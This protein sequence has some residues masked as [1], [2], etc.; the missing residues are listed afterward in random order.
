MREVEL[1]LITAEVQTAAAV[2]SP[3]PSRG[4]TAVTRRVPRRSVFT[5]TDMFIDP[6][7]ICLDAFPNAYGVTITTSTFERIA[8]ARVASITLQLALLPCYA[9]DHDI[10][11]LLGQQCLQA[12]QAGRAA[13]ADEATEAIQLFHTAPALDH[14]N[15]STSSVAGRP[16]AAALALLR[17]TIERVPPLVF[18]ITPILVH[19]AE[20]LVLP[21]PEP[22][23][24]LCTT[25]GL[26]LG[27]T[28]GRSQDE[29]IASLR[30]AAKDPSTANDRA[31]RWQKLLQLRTRVVA[32]VPP[33]RL[34]DFSVGRN[35]SSGVQFSRDAQMRGT[36]PAQT[37]T[38]SYLAFPEQQGQ[39]HNAGFPVRASVMFTVMDEDSALR[40]AT[41]LA[42]AKQGH[43]MRAVYPEVRPPACWSVQPPADWIRLVAL[44]PRPPLPSAR[45]CFVDA[46]LM[47]KVQPSQ[48]LLPINPREAD[49]AA[50]LNLTGLWLAVM[51]DALLHEPTSRWFS[52]LDVAARLPI[53]ASGYDW[54]AAARFIAAYVASG[55]VTP[56]TFVE[57]LGQG[58]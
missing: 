42:Y 47:D 44:D 2:A 30:E 41:V 3:A 50:S 43:V 32:D 55:D 5:Q 24:M 29:V 49:L 6:D 16:S 13:V 57:I 11:E 27:L 1:A 14:G 20:G 39:N 23:Y 10:D 8:G 37:V 7:T 19:S 40:L 15:Y 58:E 38:L 12:Q 21:E 9:V 36:V 4:L 28:S 33:D 53:V 48:W 22:G 17:R 52:V 25:H 54:P 35:Q 34:V 26:H 56:V 46:S 51:R 31:A 18:L 45:Y